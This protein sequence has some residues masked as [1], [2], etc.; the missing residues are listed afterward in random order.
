MQ[1]ESKF[2]RSAVGILEIRQNK[3]SVKISDAVNYC[4]I[5][6]YCQ[7]SPI[8]WILKSGKRHII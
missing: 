8:L 4:K 7:I 1:L 5:D 2:Y 3:G 6:Q